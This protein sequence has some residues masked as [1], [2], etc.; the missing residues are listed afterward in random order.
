MR[1]DTDVRIDSAE[2]HWLVVA[3]VHLSIVDSTESKITQ[4]VSVDRSLVHEQQR[5]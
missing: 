1:K 3:D 5:V 4:T 2:D